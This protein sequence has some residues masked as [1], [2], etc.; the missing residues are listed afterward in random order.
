MDY[1]IAAIC[2][3][4]MNASLFSN[5]AKAPRQQQ[6]LFTDTKSGVQTDS[7]LGFVALACLLRARRHGNHGGPQGSVS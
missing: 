4:P 7:I 2:F 5:G 6:L 3:C 1:L